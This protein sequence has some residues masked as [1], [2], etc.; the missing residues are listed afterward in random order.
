[1]CGD[2][3]LVNKQI[4]SNK[5]AMPLPE[6]IFDALG[7][8]KILNT[9]DLRSNYHHLPLRQG[10]KVKITFWGIHLHGKDCL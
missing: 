7:Q 6:K 5:Y 3:R 1:M 8:T 9:L 2:Y 10:D 4:C